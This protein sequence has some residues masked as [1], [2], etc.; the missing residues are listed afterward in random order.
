MSWSRLQLGDLV[1]L[2]NG[3]NFSEKND[4]SGLRIVRVKDFG[5]RHFVSW[6]DLSEINPKGL[7]ITDKVYLE[8]EDIVI[9]RSNGN[10]DLV[11]RSMIY[12]GPPRTTIFAGFCIR[13]RVCK[14][15]AVPQFVHYWLRSP[16]TRE[17]LSREGGGTG[18]QNVSQ[19]LLKRQEIDLPPLPE[20]REIAA[21]LGALDDKI[22]LNRRMAATLE[23]MARALYRSWFVDFDPV[24]AKAAGQPPAFM[25]EATAALFPDRFGDDG[26]PEGWEMGSVVDAF[27]IIMGQSPPGNT[28]NDDGEGLPFFQGRT[29][30]GFRFPSRRK[31]CSAPSRIAPR[32]STLLSVRAPVGDLNRAWEK[33]CIGRGVASLSEKEGR[34]AYGY[35]ALWALS[36]ALK[37]Y[38]SEGTVFG[39]INKKQLSGLSLILPPNDMRTAFEAT[40]RPMDDQIRKITAENQTLAT[41]RDTLL[42]KLM[43]GELRVGEARKR[44][45][46]VA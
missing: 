40:T 5:D 21:L 37:S 42:P 46:A 2:S 35:E 45:E 22:E 32:D 6:A 41:L 3:L 34:N 10:K 11:G 36:E 1:D 4:G 25:D 8:P 24:H 28:Y 30:F 31:F 29:D 19:G 44:V 16:T 27:D 12:D 15:Q 13:A 17:K 14:R 43:S 26:L 18:I 20:Q 33:C 9:V 38:D 39:S 23:E 7:K